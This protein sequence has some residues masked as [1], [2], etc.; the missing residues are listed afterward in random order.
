MQKR[1]SSIGTRCAEFS[2]YCATYPPSTDIVGPETIVPASEQ[3]THFPRLLW[4]AHR[5]RGCARIMSAS[6]QGL[7]SPLPPWPFGYTL[8]GRN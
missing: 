6:V 5:S 4:L 7:A 8:D 2:L 3:A 1:G